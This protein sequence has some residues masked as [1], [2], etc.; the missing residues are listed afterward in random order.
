M[1]QAVVARSTRRRDFGGGVAAAIGGDVY[2]PI[3]SPG[4]TTKPY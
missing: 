4:R 1:V 2:G 3:G